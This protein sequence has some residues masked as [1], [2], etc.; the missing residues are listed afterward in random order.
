MV[1]AQS[2]YSPSHDDYIGDKGME[3]LVMVKQGS[4]FTE[5]QSSLHKFQLRG[6]VTYMHY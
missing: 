1:G 6:K 3:P 4:K 5:V 2:M